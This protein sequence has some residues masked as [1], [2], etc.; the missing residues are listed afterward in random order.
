M[1]PLEQIK[2]RLEKMKLEYDPECPFA[3]S[4]PRN[5]PTG[6]DAWNLAISEIQSLLPSIIQE[7]IEDYS[8]W[9]HKKGYID[10]D[11]YTEE[12][13]AIDAYIVSIK[14]NKI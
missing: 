7:V 12:P 1:T 9:L 5:D 2:E 10:S 11:Y 6:T 8:N 13:H 4:D 14:E 3:F